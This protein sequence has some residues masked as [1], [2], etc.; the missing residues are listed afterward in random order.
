MAEE[1]EEEMDLGQ[2]KGQD[3][4]YAAKEGLG[5]EV[6]ELIGQGVPVGFRDNSGWTALCWASSEGH[7]DVVTLL[8]DNG[9]SEE[10]IELMVPG[11]SS[12]LHWAAYK[13][14]VRVIWTLLT[15][16]KLSPA[17]L[18]SEG[19][20]PLHLAAAGGHMLCVKAML[21]EGVDVHLANDYGNT[22]LQLS[23]SREVQELLRAAAAVDGAAFLCACSGAFVTAG[24]SVA[25]RVIDRVSA[26]TLRPVRYTTECAAKIR[27]AEDNLV[28]RIKANSDPVALKAAIDAAEATGAS[29]PLLDEGIDAL[30]RLTAQISLQTVINDIESRRPLPDRALLRPLIA[31]LKEARENGVEAAAI[32]AAD[33]LYQTVDA[34]AALVAF[35]AQCESLTMVDEPTPEP[36]LADSEF[37][38]RAEAGM[39]KLY[40]MIGVAQGVEA[41]EEVIHVAEQLH[42]RL[43]AE[44]DLRKAL[45]EPVPQ[46]PLDSGVL[47]WL[48]YNG[49]VTTSK[50]EALQLNNDQLDAALDRCAAEGVLGT[51]VAAVGS[52]QKLLKADLKQAVAEDE[53]RKAKEAAAAAKAAKKKKGGKKK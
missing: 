31:P 29:A 36:P 37:A 21:A 3:L 46:P 15:N 38:K 41:M 10:E 11:R 28:A 50:L 8:L 1:E 45:L 17:A 30:G 4:I 52:H 19:N 22:A 6:Q 43:S 40:G 12:P 18:D 48:H 27:D 16:S 39:A 2:K 9:A 47:T 33:R 26:P 53:E 42:R 14:H 34:E 25:Q 32:Q 51:I 7:V 23:T 44:S 24:E 5:S 13:G 20:T 49:T 35:V